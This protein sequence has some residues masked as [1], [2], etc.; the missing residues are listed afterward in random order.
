M[1][2][3]DRT[4]ISGDARLAAQAFGNA[5]DPAI[6]LIMG[7]ATSSVWW[8]PGFIELLVAQHRFVIRY[9]ARDTGRSTSY[10]HGTTPYDLDDLADDA[11][12]V[13]D[14]FGIARA[15]LVGMSMGGITAQI[16]ALKHPGRVR[17]L[18]LVSTQ[19][20][21]D[22]GAE[23]PDMAPDLLDFFMSSGN[24]DWTDR[25]AVI[26]H[27]VEEWRIM[28]GTRHP[29]DEPLIA[30]LAQQD[31]A[32][33]RDPRAALNH[34]GLGGGESWVDRTRDIAV[35]ALVVHG[36]ADRVID[37]AHARALERELPDARL[38]ALEGAGHE[39]HRLDWPEI[40]QAIGALDGAARSSPSPSCA[41]PGPPL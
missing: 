22:P 35:P 21:G 10:A 9:D 23:V 20:L 27:S 26:A 7:A 15:H 32:Y 25:D 29:F 39:L 17:A 18:T 40:T 19:I 12:A 28:A 34:Q 41:A 8:P 1:D 30:R 31:W 38:L 4:I 14:G 3:T 11:V 33:S 6:L 13:L 5:A 37:F 2:M 24:I 16:V 36:T